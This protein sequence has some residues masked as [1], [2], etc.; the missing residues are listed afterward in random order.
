[1]T[2]WI[3]YVCLC[4][5]LFCSKL[6]GMKAF[7]SLDETHLLKE[8]FIKL[9]ESKLGQSVGTP[10]TGS[11]QADRYTVAVYVSRCVRKLRSKQSFLFDDEKSIN[12]LLYL[13][14]ELRTEI[15]ML[16]MDATQFELEIES[17][18][19][20]SPTA[21]DNLNTEKKIA[22]QSVE[23]QAQGNTAN[24]SEFQSLVD[25]TVVGLNHIEGYLKVGVNHNNSGN[26]RVKQDARVLVDE[27]KFS[28]TGNKYFEEVRMGKYSPDLG[29]GISNASNLEGVEVLG[30][31]QDYKFQ[32]GYFDGVFAAVTSPLL[33]NL[34]VTF[35]TM[36]EKSISSLADWNPK[37][38]KHQYHSGLYFEHLSSAYKL[39]T[40]FAE[41]NQSGIKD[42]KVNE[43][44]SFSLSLDIFATNKLQIGGAM[45][46]TGENF[47]ARQGQNGLN[48][49]G[50]FD[51]S[52]K[53]L[54]KQVL[55]S[56][57]RYFGKDIYSVP[58]TSDLKFKLNYQATDKSSIE[59]NFNRLYDHTRYEIN[60]N[61][62]FNLG[63][64]N[65]IQRLDENSEFLISLQSLNWDKL[66]AAQ[67][68]FMAG[69]NRENMQSLQSAYRL[70]F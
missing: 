38:S 60:R 58:G 17:R 28:Y 68:G 8:H 27:A 63:T 48:S 57:S 62:G 54:Q 16:N 24:N 20:I 12:T 49:T 44:R 4:T 50:S 5:L 61:N 64:I 67:S 47:Q 40:E 21:L 25:L 70:R 29:M 7:D 39:R 69:H 45:T 18:F 55:K 3:I 6:F 31:Y 9:L 32:F 43:Q 30:N 26:S 19:Q 65:Y 51:S 23:I 1:M 36:Q 42:R 37:T 66:G 59:L 56:L 2:K 22:L 11:D 53:I 52:D 41:F 34:P 15:S 35:Y 14:R 46:H 10:V 33:L 13:I